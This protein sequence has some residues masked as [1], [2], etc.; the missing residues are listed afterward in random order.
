MDM[1]VKTGGFEQFDQL[2]KELP[3]RVA[4][5]VMQQSVTNALRQVRPDVRAAAPVGSDQSP[6]SQKYGRTKRNIRVIRLRRTAANEKA[7]RI[8]TGNAFWQLFYNLGTRYQQARPWFGPTIT[9]LQE[10][11]FKNL[12]DSLGKGIEREATRK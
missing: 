1:N 8:D 3:E 7:A 12:A 6:A 5:R 11:I 2:L 10:R 4:G 9:R